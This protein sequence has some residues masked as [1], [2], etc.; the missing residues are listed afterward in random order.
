MFR[1]LFSRK[2]DKNANAAETA[3]RGLPAF[4]ELDQEMKNA[5][6]HQV[7]LLAASSTIAMGFHSF[8]A[9]GDVQQ[10]FNQNPE[11]RDLGKKDDGMSIFDDAKLGIQVE[12][13]RNF[14]MLSV[15]HPEPEVELASFVALVE[16]SLLQIGVREGEIREG[17]VPKSKAIILRNSETRQGTLVTVGPGLTSFVTEAGQPVIGF[18]VIIAVNHPAAKESMT[19]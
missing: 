6:P 18:I 2:A 17:K 8:L 7:R 4:A 5:S 14:M 1:K 11:F 15:V 16:K 9:E 13:A 10:A 12:V 3:F 19:V